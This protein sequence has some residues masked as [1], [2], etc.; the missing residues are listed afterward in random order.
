[1]SVRDQYFSFS[2]REDSLA[3]FLHP[4]QQR[5]AC[6][7]TTVMMIIKQCLLSLLGYSEKRNMVCPLHIALRARKK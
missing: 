2:F 7:C 5:A 3:F 4:P 1:M 6:G